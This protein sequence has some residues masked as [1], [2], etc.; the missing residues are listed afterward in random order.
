MFGDQARALLG[1]APDICRRRLDQHLDIAAAGHPQHAEAEPAAEIA[2]AGV[3]F[4]PL[5]VR[6]HLGG[7]PHL[8][9]G[10][11][12]VDRLQHQF[13]IERK[14]QFSDHD[15]RRLVA[16]ERHEIA[17]A[18]F[19]LDREAELFEEA[20]DGQIKRGFQRDSRVVGDSAAKFSPDRRWRMQRDLIKRHRNGYRVSGTRQARR[21][22]PRAYTDES[23]PEGDGLALAGKRAT[24]CKSKLRL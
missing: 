3:A 12:A 18:D 20:F 10:A 9:A 17:A 6:R 22:Y 19:A 8:V 15:E 23:A 7:E 24:R 14:F 2:I 1:I 13:E 21:V 16:A 11:G 5:A 4:A